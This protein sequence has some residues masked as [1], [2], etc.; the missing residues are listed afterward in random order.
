[1]AAVNALQSMK[2][3]L[4]GQ[5]QR[6]HEL[7]DLVSQFNVDMSG[8][9]SLIG[10]RFRGCDELVNLKLRELNFSLILQGSADDE[11]L[12]HVEKLKTENDQLREELRTLQEVHSEEMEELAREAAD[13]IA[14]HDEL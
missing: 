11:M 12:Q 13:R 10:E 3:E 1:V 14:E 6:I 2:A 5:R 7:E 4:E 8:V 9:M